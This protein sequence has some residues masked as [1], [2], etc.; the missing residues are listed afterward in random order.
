MRTLR[1]WCMTLG[2]LALAVAL[3]AGTRGWA[4]KPAG[5]DT[6]AAHGFDVSDL[7]TSCKA[8]DNF[9][10]YATGGWTAQVRL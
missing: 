6:A 3:A 10:Q 5:T 1:L 2:V 8:C 9:F 4:Q 7:D